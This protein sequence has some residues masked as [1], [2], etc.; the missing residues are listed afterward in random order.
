LRRQPDGSPDPFALQQEK[1]CDR[2][3]AT[4]RVPVDPKTI[5][6]RKPGFLADAI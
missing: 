4:G 3:G 2:C 6:E 5:V 1:L